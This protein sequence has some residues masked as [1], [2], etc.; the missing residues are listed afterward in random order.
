MARTE[1]TMLPLGAPAPDFALPDVTTGKTVSLGDFRGKAGLL[2]IFMCRHCPFVIHV[3][4]ELARLGVDF[5]PQELGIV[6]ISAN[7]AENYPDDGP[8][9]LKEMA[10]AL[11]LNFPILYDES[12]AIAK[13]YQAACT[14]DFF[15]FDQDLKLVY[16]GQLDDAR[17][18]NDKPVTGADLRQAIAAVLA[19]E[20][21]DPNQKPSLGCNIKWKP[22]NAPSYFG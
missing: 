13:S 18:G 10:A 8:E 11:Q 7:D 16:R 6:A 15:L 21:P 12:Q 19:K 3:Q 4:D 17:P 22:G 14:P 20:T 2:V 5:V 1:S 9:K